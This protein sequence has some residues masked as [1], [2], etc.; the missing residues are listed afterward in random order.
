MMKERS[1]EPISNR[2]DLYIFQIFFAVVPLHEMSMRKWCKFFTVLLYIQ[3]GMSQETRF[4][5]AN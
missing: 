5:K 1:P 3:N 2:S 4:G